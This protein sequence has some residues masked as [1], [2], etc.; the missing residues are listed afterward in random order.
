MGTFCD[1]LL[2]ARISE[3]YATILHILNIGN[4]TVITCGIQRGN[5]DPQNFCSFF[6]CNKFFHEAYSLQS[7]KFVIVLSKS[8]EYAGRRNYQ[9]MV[10]DLEIESYHSKKAEES[11][12]N[13]YISASRHICHAP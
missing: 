9:R 5:T 7:V 8:H 6:S 13:L 3:V 1:I 4:Q 2:K 12:S 11:L 10:S